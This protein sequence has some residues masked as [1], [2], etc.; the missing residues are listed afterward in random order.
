MEQVISS[1]T[2]KLLALSM[3]KGVGPAALKKVASIASFDGMAIEELG[4]AVAQVARA[5]EAEP[6]SVWSL[7]QD[8]ANKQVEAAEKHRARIL[9]PLDPDYPRLLAETKD[10]PF[11]LYV[12][13]SLA[14]D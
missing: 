13:G 1:P 3:L 8:A 9:S 11:L 12:K 2:L 10:D 14:R 7:A 5:L 6:T 4:R